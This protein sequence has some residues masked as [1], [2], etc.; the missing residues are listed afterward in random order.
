MKQGQSGLAIIGGG[1]C[2]TLFLH[3][4]LFQLEKKAGKGQKVPI[5][6]LW[7]DQKGQHGYAAPFAPDQPPSLLM[8]G[9]TYMLTPSL[10][11]PSVFH[12]FYRKRT[13][14]DDL[15][16]FIPRY[17]YGHFLKKLAQE[18]EDR[19]REMGIQLVKISQGV[20]AVE[21]NHQGGLSIYSDTGM[22]IPVSGVALATGP[23]RNHKQDHLQGINGYIANPSRL[24]DFYNSSLDLNNPCTSIACFGPGASCFD[25]MALLENELGYKGSY[26]AIGQRDIPLWVIRRNRPVPPDA[27]FKL[28]HLSAAQLPCPLNV[29]DLEEHF[30]KECQSLDDHE[31]NPYEMGPE[32]PL[33]SLAAYGHQIYK[34]WVQAHNPDPL[35]KA[36]AKNAFDYMQRKALKTLEATTSPAMIE[37]YNK[38]K[39]EGRILEV[40]GRGIESQIRKEKGFFTIPV[41]RQKDGIKLNYRC[42]GF[43]NTSPYS[44]EWPAQSIDSA[45][46]SPS[47]SLLLRMEK[48]GLIHKD[49]SN[50]FAL[51]A[52]N[53]GNIALL[54]AAAD[55]LWGVHLAALR[56]G[57]TAEHFADKLLRQKAPSHALA[58]SGTSTPQKR[59]S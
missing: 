58:N 48:E 54:G 42:Q 32:Y 44:R 18:L 28:Y 41:I 21:E 5:R 33:F 59:V 9:P 55:P 39:A 30:N 12:D 57:V 43:I 26:V 17:H 20:S 52:P 16:G 13:G 14:D 7:F 4:L 50:P 37:L 51:Y 45:S 27:H 1:Q 8:N 29:S 23:A 2:G 56:N 22:M 3:D 34:M 53:R 40:K 36:Q 25:A 24:D 10:A 35:A 31:R 46:A 47:E 15:D 11:R 6:I 19:A 38:L 49:N